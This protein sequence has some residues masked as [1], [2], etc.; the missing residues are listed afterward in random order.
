M[1]Y[2]WALKGAI[3]LMVIYLRKLF[4]N[5]PKMYATELS[6]FSI[7]IIGTTTATALTRAILKEGIMSVAAGMNPMDLRRGIN[8]AVEHV[9][10]LL[11]KRAQMISTTEEVA[12][13]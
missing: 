4:M 8:A 13:V 5:P 1:L 10:Q 11:K 7:L 12:Q 9:V 3:L 2:L 6:C